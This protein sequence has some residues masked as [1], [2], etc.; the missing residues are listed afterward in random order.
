MTCLSCHHSARRHDGRLWCC[1]LA[2]P[3]R[4]RCVMFLYEPGTDESE[5]GARQP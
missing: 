1:L 4:E 2:K 5:H 3:A